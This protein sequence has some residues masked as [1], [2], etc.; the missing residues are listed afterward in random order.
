MLRGWDACG[1]G[2]TQL[3]LQDFF[4]GLPVNLENG[5]AILS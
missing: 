5:K 4:P 1:A 3:L 2:K